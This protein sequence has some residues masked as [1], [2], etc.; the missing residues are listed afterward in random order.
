MFDLGSVG[1]WIRGV[2]EG[3]EELHRFPDPK[4][5]S[6]LFKRFSAGFDVERDSLLG[7]LLTTRQPSSFH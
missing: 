4:G 7:M 5:R 6:R 1:D 3:I 2:D